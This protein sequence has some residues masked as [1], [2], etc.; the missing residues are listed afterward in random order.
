[1]SWKHIVPKTK[2]VIVDDIDGE[3]GII[4]GHYGIAVDVRLKDG[5][6]KTVRVKRKSGHVVGDLVTITP[7]GLNPFPRM[8]EVK[9]IDMRGNERII[10]ANLDVIGIVIAP[11][12]PTPPGFL[13]R[14]FVAAMASGIKPFIVVNKSDEKGAAELYERIKALYGNYFPIFYVSAE[15]ETNL[16]ELKQFFT[17]GDYRGAFIGTSG[18]GKS[19]LLNRFCPEIELETCE[20]NETG[21]F[22]RHAT[23]ASTLH[24]LPTGGE[25]IDTPGFRDFR[26]VNISSE[27]L[28]WYFPDFQLIFDEGGCRFGD[29]KHMTEPGCVILEAVKNGI[30][31]E[32][33][34]HIYKTI[35]NEIKTVEDGR[36]KDARKKR[37][38]GGAR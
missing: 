29:C 3:V 13:D 2:K 27:D 17:D 37:R 15:E 33:R 7:T 25:L 34:H 14:A 12:P 32:E 21:G 5:S 6:V 30:L 36:V 35:H 26:V 24:I 9:R 1:M 28:A 11:Q 22:G 19:S 20:I 8:T 31:P 38:K 16:G 23:T 10:A 4:K 18:V